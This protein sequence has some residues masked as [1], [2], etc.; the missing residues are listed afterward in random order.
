VIDAVVAG[1]IV[2]LATRALGLGS[3]AAAA[4]GIP[5]APL[6]NPAEM[7]LLGVA[8]MRYLGAVKVGLGSSEP[9]HR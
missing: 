8:S 3:P 2:F 6:S 9:R 5:G 7:G 1:V 4:L